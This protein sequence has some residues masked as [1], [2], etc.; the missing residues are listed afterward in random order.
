MADNISGLGGFVYVQNASA[1]GTQGYDTKFE[2]ALHSR[3]TSVIFGDN[4]AIGAMQ[5]IFVPAG[6]QFTD[7]DT[8]YSSEDIVKLFL[9]GA[10]GHQGLEGF[11]GIQ[12][13]QG[14]QGPQGKQ[15]NKGVQGD[16]GYQGNQGII[17]PQGYRGKQGYIGAQGDPGVQGDYGNQGN[18]GV[19]GPQGYRGDKGERG[20]WQGQP[21]V[22]GDPGYQGNQGIIGPQGYQGKKGERSGWQGVMGTQGDQ[23][24]QGNQGYPGK[25]GIAGYK[26]HI[27][28]QGVAGTQGDQAAQGNQGYPGKQGQQGY[29]G[30]PSGL[31]GVMGTQGDQ[32]ARGNQGYPGKQGTA[33]YK[34]HIGPQGVAGTQG[35]QAARGN[36]GN[37][38]KQG[39][40]GYKGHIGPQ[41]VAGTQG[42]QA[43]QGR[44]GYPGKQGN[45]GNKGYYTGQ[46][47]VPGI[48]GDQAAKG[49]QGLLGQQGV[50]GSRGSTGNQGILGAQGGIGTNGQA[51]WK[52][53]QGDK[54]IQG[55]DGNVSGHS[56][57]AYI[58]SLAHSHSG[59][60]TTSHSHSGYI[61]SMAHS[62]SGYAASS[63]T[64]N[65]LTSYSTRPSSINYNFHDDSIRKFVASS[66]CS[67][68][69]PAWDANIL[70]LAW[71]GSSY[72]TQLAIGTSN[73]GLA[74]RSE[75]NGTWNDWQYVSL[76]NHSHSGYA[77]TSHSHSAYIT[78]LAHSHSA[79]I[80]SLAHSHSDYATTSHS[81]G[82]YLPLSGGTMSGCITTKTGVSH[83]G[84]KLG[85]TYLT[86]I[87]GEVIFQNNTAIRFGGDS[88]DWNVWAELGYNHSSKIVYLG[89]AGSPYSANSQQTGGK[90][91]TPGV[92]N[93]YIGNGSYVV[94][95][96]GNVSSYAVTN[97][98]HSHSAYITSLAHSHSGYA[99]TS[100]SHS[101]FSVRSLTKDALNS[102]AG[103]YFFS[104]ANLL[105]LNYDWAGLQVD[106]G[107][108]KFQICANGG[109]LMVRQ[110]DTGGSNSSSWSSWV[111]LATDS[112]S[113]SGYITSLAHSHSG[114]LTSLSHSHSGYI[115]SLAHSHSGYLSTGGGT[116][117]GSLTINTDNE[118]LTIGTGTNSNSYA[119][120]SIRHATANWSIGVG[121]NGL[122]FW[123]G[124]S[125]STVCNITNAGVLYVG[126]TSVS[127]SNH[128][129][130]GYAG[131]SHSH[132]A[133]ITSLA[134]S[135]SA[136]IT[137]LAHSHSDYATTS[138]SHSGYAGTSHSHS[139]YITSLAHSHSGY[140]TSLSHSHSAYGVQ[141]GDNNFINHTNEFNFTPS[142][143]ANRVWFNYRTTGG[144]N[145]NISEYIFG[146]GDGTSLGTAIHTGNISSYAITSLAHSHS[147]YASTSHSHSEYSGGGSPSVSTNSN[148][149]YLVGHTSTSG[150]LS[151]A[152]CN[153]SVWMQSGNL[154]ASSDIRL[155]ENL[156]SIDNEFV[157]KVYNNDKDLI[158]D[159]TW[160]DSQLE[161][162]GFIAQYLEELD[163][164]LVNTDEDTNIK[165]VNY[166]AALSKMV[167][168]LFKKTKEQDKRINEQEKRI[169][170][171][172]NVI[173]QLLSINQN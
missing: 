21:G 15:G 13:N 112:H 157:N 128:S 82:G 93:I 106:G 145:G 117:S 76:T 148:K 55:A 19:I 132:S 60:A 156:K 154:Y 25:Q 2:D 6:A 79:Y 146:K 17:G 62:H 69:K 150:T 10:Q 130:S 28:P 12:G 51:G 95:H 153:S 97:M 67:T 86:S 5:N 54:G 8:T 121:S 92:D 31:Q 107:N 74:F 173:R 94:L 38:G 56:H 80:T 81:H 18:Q 50:Q 34:G 129:H 168:V 22:Q 70:H 162:T 53:V 27:G 48:Q 158:Y 89:L 58:T 11:Y 33:G 75:S 16:Q 109:T 57:S 133:Y 90:I 151:T 36:Q 136:Y 160:K 116:L 101:D 144:Y 98:A 29:K 1:Q 46:Q 127:L 42:D 30:I 63:H 85:D 9:K 71:E 64:H 125:R 126:G 167:G 103:T 165:S 78:S 26:G 149:I 119:C 7:N 35:D 123:T 84:I 65:V 77:G 171:L 4:G 137:S 61:T 135:H 23:A 105:G 39:T 96:S 115:T 172:E 41:G 147:G 47:G 114:Y 83:N 113:H 40:A 102:T 49:K 169:N 152:Y 124:Y 161:T 59:Y 68:G 134:H 44:Q 140:I 14:V 72:D 24:A 37:P 3:P 142:G 120:V 91:Y 73:Q 32:A 164:N 20:G 52:G 131:T 141:G 118:S 110:N 143:F 87:N 138:H 111:N 104:S 45:Q 108:D 122:Y 139:A 163:P 43:V 66:S 99:G 170:E 88:W 159:F 155:K 166:N 100:H